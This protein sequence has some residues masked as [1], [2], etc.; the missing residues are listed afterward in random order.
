[1]R[2]METGGPR[3]RRSFVLAKLLI[4]PISRQTGWSPKLSVGSHPVPGSEFV[5]SLPV[6][7]QN[8]CATRKRASLCSDM[9]KTGQRSFTH[10][11][12]CTIG[13]S[14]GGPQIPGS[15]LP[16]INRKTKADEETSPRGILLENVICKRHSF[17]YPA[18]RGVAEGPAGEEL[19][20]VTSRPRERGESRRPPLR[21]HDHM[22]EGLLR[23]GTEVASF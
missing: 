12:S 22:Q 20:A 23:R 18:G 13:K 14:R 1:M 9:R 5:S 15:L 21:S 8:S 3:P 17:R 16:P 7:G 10:F 11:S 2:S 19:P 4:E 6:A